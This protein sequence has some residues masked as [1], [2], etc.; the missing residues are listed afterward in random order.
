MSRLL[1]AAKTLGAAALWA[2]FVFQIFASQ[3]LNFR[4]A[5]AG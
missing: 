1:C 5:S 3:F 4:P 2:F